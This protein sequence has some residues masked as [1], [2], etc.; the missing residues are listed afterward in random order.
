MSDSTTVERLT[1]SHVGQ[2]FDGALGWHNNARVI[3]MAQERG[4]ALDL[5]DRSVLRLYETGNEKDNALCRECGRPVAALF[6]HPLSHEIQL[7]AH[8]APWDS[9]WPEGFLACS[10]APE[11]CKATTLDDA[12][13]DAAGYVLDQ[14]GL[15]DAAVDWLDEHVAPEGYAF[16]FDDGFHLRALED[17]DEV[18]FTHDCDDCEYLGAW[19]TSYGVRA[20]LYHCPPPG[21]LVARYSSDGPDYESASLERVATT[22]RNPDVLTEALR[23]YQNRGK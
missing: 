6:Y 13:I 8:L 5:L 4:M 22:T 3:R 23:R 9:L 17:E 20:E 7:I 1:R 12:M 18:V 21:S 2:I 10:D 16:E 15:L 19:V 14:G 11:T